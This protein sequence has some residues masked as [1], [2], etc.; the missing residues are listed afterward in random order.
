VGVVVVA[1][2]VLVVYGLWCITFIFVEVEALEAGFKM[3]VLQNKIYFFPGEGFNGVGG[4]KVL[5][6]WGSSGFLNY[7]GGGK[8]LEG[9][10][11][12]TGARAERARRRWR[13]ARNSGCAREAGASVN[14]IS[15]KQ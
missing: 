4:F 10:R 5:I 14:A 11:V 2:F 8:R 13:R 9:S 7:T 3:A 15:R 12:G 1:V 6:L